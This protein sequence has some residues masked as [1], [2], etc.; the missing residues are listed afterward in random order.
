MPEHSQ[1]HPNL[2]ESPSGVRRFRARCAITMIYLCFA[3]LLVFVGCWNERI[4]QPSDSQGLVTSGVIVL[5]MGVA[6]GTRIRL[7]LRNAESNEFLSEPGLFDVAC[8]AL[9]VVLFI[10]GCV[11]IVMLTR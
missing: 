3:Q 4:A 9:S 7:M 2:Q 6:N 1:R 8:L 11:L 10:V 5:A